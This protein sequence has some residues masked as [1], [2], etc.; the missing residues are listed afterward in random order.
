MFDLILKINSWL[1]EEVLSP[2]DIHIIKMESAD[3]LADEFFRKIAATF[4]LKLTFCRIR[5]LRIEA[6]GVKRRQSKIN[7]K[8]F[9]GSRQARSSPLLFDKYEIY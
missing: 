3:E 5:G 4:K 1:T 7:K 2:F 8:R 6:E 9:S